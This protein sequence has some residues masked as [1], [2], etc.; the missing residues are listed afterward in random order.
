MSNNCRQRRSRCTIKQFG[1]SVRVQIR[2]KKASLVGEGYVSYITNV[3]SCVSDIGSS[4]SAN[5][6]TTI[7]GIVFVVIGK[8]YMD[9]D[10]YGFKRHE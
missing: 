3:M 9:K 5:P 2:N 8:M 1:G 6:S 4:G 10:R 7:T